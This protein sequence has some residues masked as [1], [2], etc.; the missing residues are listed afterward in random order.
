MAALPDAITR[1]KR[2][3]YTGENRC[4][5][6]TTV[7]VVI[8]IGLAAGIA[9][10]SVPA[11]ALSIGVFLGLIYLRGYLIPGTPTLTRRYLPDRVLEWFDKAEPP[12]RRSSIETA[13]LDDAVESLSA[14][15]VVHGRADG[16]GLGLTPTF[17]KRWRERL[18]SEN[19][20][21]G[22][23]ENRGDVRIQ[24]A[25]DIEAL[26]D[27]DE[28][29]RRSDATVE[30]DGTRLLRWESE[31]ALTADIAADRELR[32]RLEGWTALEPDDRRDVLTG[33][34]LLGERCPACNGRLETRREGVEH[35]CRRP[36]DALETKCTDCDRVIA[37]VTVTESDPLLEWV[38]ERD[39]PA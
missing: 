20:R 7:N 8:A 9:T 39:V 32:N 29:E 5:P 33:L 21:E 38:P 36:R 34:R 14:A 23:R 13:D 26:V 18:A 37:A 11:G 28:V 31:A 27:A 1:I 35:C 17:R 30:L 19:A 3:E 15:D 6:C 16:N 4:L 2:P 24:N 10:V 12:A 25:D 22:E